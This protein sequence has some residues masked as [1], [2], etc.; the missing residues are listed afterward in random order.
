MIYHEEHEAKKALEYLSIYIVVKERPH[1]NTQFLVFFLLLN[2]LHVLH[3][4]K[5]LALFIVQKNDL[6]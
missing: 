5:I 2:A 4:E 1:P 3:G 6:P